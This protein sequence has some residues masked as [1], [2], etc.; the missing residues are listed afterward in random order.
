MARNGSLY[1]HIKREPR[2]RQQA[3]NAAEV[4][5][6]RWVVV[7]CLRK[8]PVDSPKPD[9]FR[10]ALGSKPHAKKTP[11]SA[12]IWPP[13]ATS[14]LRECMG[15]VGHMASLALE[16]RSVRSGPLVRHGE[17]CIRFERLERFK[18][19]VCKGKE[20]DRGCQ[21]HRVHEFVFG[22]VGG[23]YSFSSH[24]RSPV[25]DPVPR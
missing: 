9:S 19:L 4:P 5:T 20:S 25:V 7:K 3:S 22:S 2:Y 16:K 13:I 15:R 12:C 8:R 1:A 14:L 10:G 23:C 11:T 21:N 18:P 6:N 17:R 24:L